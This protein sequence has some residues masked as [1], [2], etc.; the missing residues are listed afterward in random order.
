MSCLADELKLSASTIILAVLSSSWLS[1]S[2]LSTAAIFALA[3]SEVALPVRELSISAWSWAPG[4]CLATLLAGLPLASPTAHRINPFPTKRSQQNKRVQKHIKVQLFQL[5][6]YIMHT[7]R[8]RQHKNSSDVLQSSSLSSCD[9]PPPKR[10][11][12]KL[13]F[14]GS[15]ISH[16]MNSSP[17]SSCKSLLSVQTTQS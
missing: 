4:M 1:L 12:K 13:C 7:Y 16:A 3:I 2:P 11:L 15:G 5:W 8:G 9:T 6:M 10:P 17:N 14:G